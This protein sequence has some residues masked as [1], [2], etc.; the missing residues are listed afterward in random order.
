MRIAWVTDPHLNFV[1]A[2]GLIAFCDTIAAIGADRL[3]I[4]GDIGEA[5]SVGRF[6]GQMADRIE[7]PIDFVLGNHDF[8]GAKIAEVRRAMTEITRAIPTLNWLPESGV[9][10]LGDRVAL[11]GHDG[12]GDA[13]L[14]N[15]R[16]SEIRL[17]DYRLIPDFAGLE[18][19]ALERKL[20]ALGDEAAA[21][22]REVVPN[23]LDRA[24]TVI[25]ATHVPPFRE[26]CV[27]KGRPANDDW[28][29]HFS[30]GSVG[31]A[32]IEIL[33]ARPDRRMLILCGHVHSPGTARILPNLSTLTGEANYRLPEVCRVFALPDDLD[34]YF[35]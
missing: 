3:V 35:T 14:G 15:F 32:L 13:R 6:L 34:A 18:P 26:S 1:D 22:V 9:V 11:V 29:P 19:G 27:F 33:E 5:E 4:T 20:N 10:P 17:N 30:C 28:L 7:S 2:E 25:F 8:Y 24:E 31:R 16:N 12:W 21:F 23:A